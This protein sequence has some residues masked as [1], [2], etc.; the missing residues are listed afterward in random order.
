VPAR[1]A[2]EIPFRTVQAG[3]QF[4]YSCAVDANGALSCWGANCFNQLG[5]DSLIEQCGT[6]PMPCST[7][8][9]P[10]H[11]AGSFQ[12]VGAA[13]SHTCA[14]TAAGAI[15]C[16]GDNNVG[17]LGNSNSGDRSVTPVAILGSQTY[18]ALSVGRE[19]TCAITDRGAPLCWG[20]NDKGQLGIGVAGNRTV[21]TPLAEP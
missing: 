2:G 7:K 21:P 10:V 13:F 9:S 6:P 15:L 14:L 17:Q 19:F 8:P 11:V 5:A 4:D 18:R 1:V 3:A 20:M 16:W 12:A